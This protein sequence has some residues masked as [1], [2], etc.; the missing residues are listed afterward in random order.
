MPS[1][2]SPPQLVIA[3]MVAAR[4]LLVRSGMEVVLL[5]IVGSIR[6]HKSEAQVSSP[7]HGSVPA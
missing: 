3:G 6:P 2:S 1:G 4:F 7:G 5:V